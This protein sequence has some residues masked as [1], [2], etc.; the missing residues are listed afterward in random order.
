MRCRAC[1]CELSDYEAKLKFTEI[2]EY[3]DLCKECLRESG[4]PYLESKSDNEE[5]KI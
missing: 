5:N 1:D 3:I 2:N 4:I